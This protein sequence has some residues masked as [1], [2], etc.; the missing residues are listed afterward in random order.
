MIRYC[1]E[2]S[3]L[4][5]RTFSIRAGLLASM[6]TP[7]RTAPVLSVTMPATAL[8]QTRR[9]PTAEAQHTETLPSLSTS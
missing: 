2:A 8:G 9:A 3:L 7:G 4:V 6:V 5:D 1:P